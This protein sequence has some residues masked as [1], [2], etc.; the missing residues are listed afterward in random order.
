MFRVLLKLSTARRTLVFFGLV[1]V[2]EL[3]FTLVFIPP[4]EATVGSGIPD[5]LVGFDIGPYRAV[6]EAMSAGSGLSLYRSIEI[7]DMVFPLISA[8][9]LAALIGTCLKVLDREHGRLR[10]LLLLPLATAFC[11]YAENFIILAITA[12]PSS[13]EALILV[14]FAATWGKSIFLIIA[15]SVSLVLGLIAVTHRSK[16]KAVLT[17]RAPAP[18]GP[19][20]Q[21]V[22]TGRTLFISGQLG[23]DP[24]TGNLK[25]DL[26]SQ[27]EQALENIEAILEAEGGTTG[28]IVKTTIFMT[29]LREF[30]IVNEIYAQ[31]FSGVFPARST[32][33]VSALPKGGL[34]EIE[35]TARLK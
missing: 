32:V 31:K 13:N 15:I 27:T 22:K 2:F 11:D 5:S 28:D 9:S 16:S 34:V 25:L 26:R 1:L 14:A 24:E 35:A 7:L 21:A 20:S 23:L 33:Q 8:L 3:L 10:F 19:Y 17:V 6:L 30:S 12:S 18:I 29:D 4:F